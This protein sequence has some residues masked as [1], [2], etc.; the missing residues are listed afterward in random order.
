MYP[1]ST[2]DGYYG[3]AGELLP[4]SYFDYPET[5]NGDIEWRENCVFQDDLRYDGYYRG[6]SAAGFRFVSENDGKTYNMFMKDFDDAMKARRFFKDRLIGQ[7]T[8]VKRGQ[9][10]GIRIIP[11]SDE[12]PDNELICGF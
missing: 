5:H 11:E 8:Y 3:R 7:F 4:Y 2:R 1:F 9:N 10:Y 6:R 12:T